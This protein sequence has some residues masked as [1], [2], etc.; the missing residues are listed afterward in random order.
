MTF[1]KTFIL[2]VCLLVAVPLF[3]GKRIVQEGTNLT[4]NTTTQQEL[5][6][7]GSRF[8]ANYATSSVIFLTDGGRNRMIT[9]DKGRNEYMEI[10]Q[11]TMDQMGQAMA[12][13]NAQ[14]EAAMKGMP[15]EQRA[16]MEQMMA[17]MMKGK[18]A[19]A[20]PAVKTVYTSKGRGT[21]NGF[22]CTNYDGMKGAEKVAEVCA[23][24]PADL[25][26]AASDFQVFRK[27]QEF[28]AGMMQAMQN[29]P[30]ASAIN[31]NVGDATVDGYPVQQTTFRNGQATDR[32]VVKSVTD[33]TFTDADF[34]VG[35]AKKMEMPDMGGAGK[36]KGKGK[37][38]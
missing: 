25:R 14:M 6:L 33:A 26:L 29:S 11:A 12:G 2:C 1:M 27:M 3:A 5:L 31:I 37:G 10:D 24:Q 19:A 8:R 15:P 22:A 13:V 30:I 7:D 34:S 16:Q 36:G 38:N 35:N 18:M 9:L 20:A 21:V 4:N 32:F 28:T 17:Q 23:A